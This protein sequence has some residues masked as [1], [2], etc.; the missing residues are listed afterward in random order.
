MAILGLVGSYRNYHL[1]ASVRGLSR[2]VKADIT[3][4]VFERI[5]VA[6]SSVSLSTKKGEE[7]SL[8]HFLILN[9]VTLQ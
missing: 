5:A 2:R 9:R 8:G 3:Q 1:L 6:N 7:N 4:I